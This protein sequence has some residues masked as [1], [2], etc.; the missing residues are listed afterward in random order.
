M[1]AEKRNVVLEKVWVL[2]R[3]GYSLIALAMIL[4]MLLLYVPEVQAPF[5]AAYNYVLFG[6]GILLIL[7][8]KAMEIIQY[9]RLKK[10]YVRC[11]HCGWYGPGTDWYDREGC[12]D[13]DSE[14]VVVA[15]HI[16]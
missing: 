10:V 9:S 8:N 2:K 13:C 6:I 14:H 4:F 7:A 11:A 12:P 15:S 1:S 16:N 3:L 5:L